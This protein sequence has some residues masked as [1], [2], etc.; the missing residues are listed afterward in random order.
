MLKKGVKEEGAYRTDLSKLKGIAFRG[1]VRISPSNA[2]AIRCERVLVFA[3]QAFHLH[4]RFQVETLEF[5][6]LTAMRLN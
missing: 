4:D 1:L 6:P 5:G 2:P 3:L